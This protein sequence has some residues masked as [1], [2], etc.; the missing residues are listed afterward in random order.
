MINRIKARRF[1]NNQ[2]QDVLSNLTG[3]DRPKISR[4]ENGFVEPKQS[5]KEALAK[6]LKTSVKDLF[7]E[8]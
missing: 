1:I 2:T 4:I 8:K 7:P 6:A 5:E 3:L